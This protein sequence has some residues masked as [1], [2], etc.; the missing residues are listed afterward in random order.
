MNVNSSKETGEMH[1]KVSRGT[2]LRK[3]KGDNL[4]LTPR[5]TGRKRQ[6]PSQNRDYVSLDDIEELSSSSSSEGFSIAVTCDRCGAEIEGERYCCVQ[7]SNYDLCIDCSKR[8]LDC[9]DV[10]HDWIK[11]GPKDAHASGRSTPQAQSNIPDNVMISSNPKYTAPVAPMMATRTSMLH[12]THSIGQPPLA[13]Q[14]MAAEEP[15]TAGLAPVK[16]NKSVLM[17][18]HSLETES[19]HQSPCPPMAQDI[20]VSAEVSASPSSPSGKQS[21]VVDS[22]TPGTAPPKDSAQPEGTLK[23]NKASDSPSTSGHS[24]KN[25]VA[26]PA[27]HP[28]PVEG[29]QGQSTEAESIISQRAGN[30]S[31][32]PSA[33]NVTTA[34]KPRAKTQVP[35]WIIT[36]EPGYLEERWDEGRFQGT[37]LSFFI[38]EL[39][40]KTGRGNI[41]K[42]LLT[43]KIPTGAVKVTVLKDAEDSWQSARKKFVEKLK[44]AA[45]DARKRSNEVAEFEIFV[46]PCYEQKV[47]LDSGLDDDEAEFEF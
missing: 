37:S 7:C 21:R 23:L 15:P 10:K 34:S 45:V 4:D 31:R 30:S 26:Q 19:P 8:G 11:V 20:I 36:R 40:K 38:D 12:N 32:D 25:S 29:Q 24:K 43:L 46:E 5:R 16:I 3:R 17:N 33:E 39:S 13:E 9:G 27:S 6:A 41:E 28:S 2:E 18:D 22:S 35:L 42:L 1:Q 47:T 44:G 14:G